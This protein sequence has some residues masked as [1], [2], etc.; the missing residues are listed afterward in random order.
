M[1]A[2]VYNLRRGLTADEKVIDHTIIVFIIVIL[3]LIVIPSAR[4]CSTPVFAEYC[5]FLSI[6]LVSMYIRETLE[7]SVFPSC[8]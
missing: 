7:L 2:F 4:C 6:L 8:F 3:A 5:P 1:L